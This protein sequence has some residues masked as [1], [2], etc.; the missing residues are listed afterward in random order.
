MAW[1]MYTRRGH[2]LWKQSPAWATEQA[3]KE[4]RGQVLAGQ[5]ARGHSGTENASLR[6]H[7]LEMRAIMEI[8]RPRWDRPKPWGLGPSAS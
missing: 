1:A 3:G 7:P 8:G 5:L 2:E 4:V 6:S